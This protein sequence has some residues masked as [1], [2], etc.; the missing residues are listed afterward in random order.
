MNYAWAK[1]APPLEISVL[2]SIS[3]SG[4]GFGLTLVNPLVGVISDGL[5]WDAAFYVTGMQKYPKKYLSH[6]TKP[7]NI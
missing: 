2:N 3:L 4:M 6:V 7:L 1:W 5:G